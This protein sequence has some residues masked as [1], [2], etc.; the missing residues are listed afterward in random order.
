[1]GTVVGPA[2]LMS[3]LGPLSARA[4]RHQCARVCALTS[5]PRARDVR[6][7]RR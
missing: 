7:R 4:P 2:D 5:V 1:M 3:L 6:R